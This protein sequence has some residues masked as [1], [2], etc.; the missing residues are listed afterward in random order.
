M[1]YGGELVMSDT[2][3]LNSPVGST[4]VL[5]ASGILVLMG[6]ATRTV[7]GYLAKGFET[8]ELIYKGGESLVRAA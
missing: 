7:I 2:M 5:V 6:T 3:V 4:V 8:M 1:I